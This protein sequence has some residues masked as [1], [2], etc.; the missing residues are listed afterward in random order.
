MLKQV[1][2]FAALAGVHTGIAALFAYAHG[3]HSSPVVT[4]ATS[5]GF[6]MAG[7]LS[8]AFTGH[9][10]HDR[11]NTTGQNTGATIY[12]LTGYAIGSAAG[13]FIR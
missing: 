7:I 13:Y 1:F 4:G 3:G 11:H 2:S 9:H 12:G 10:I 6:A 5:F 8:G